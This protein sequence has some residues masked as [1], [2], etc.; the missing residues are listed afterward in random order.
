MIPIGFIVL[1]IIVAISGI[2][3]HMPRTKEIPLSEEEIESILI[4]HIIDET[5]EEA[6][7]VEDASP[8]PVYYPPTNITKVGFGS[9]KGYLYVKIEFLGRLPKEKDDLITKITV[10]ILMNTDGNDSSGW[11]GYDACIAFYITW[12]PLGSPQT[13]ACI[14]YNIATTPNEEEAFEKATRIPGEYKGGL[15]KNYVILRVSMDLLDLSSRQ[16]V[17]MDIHAEAKVASIII[18]LLMLLM[19]SQYGYKGTGN[20][21]WH[22]VEIPIP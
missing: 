2:L 15:G 19:S 22:S 11:C 12:D 3:T 18:I 16:H 9:Y 5:D 17:V 8:E 20:Y 1:V 14:T 13:E 7:L 21:F 6:T 4:L 10:C